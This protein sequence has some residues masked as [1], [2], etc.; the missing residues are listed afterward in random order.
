MKVLG[1]V[2]WMLWNGYRQ[3]PGVKAKVL[4]HHSAL[5]NM[6][7]M[8]HD[9]VTL[10]KA[11]TKGWAAAVQDALH[12]LDIGTGDLQDVNG[13]MI[14]NALKSIRLC[15]AWEHDVYLRWF[16]WDHLEIGD[17]RVG[18]F[19]P[20]NRRVMTSLRR[21]KTGCHDLNIVTGVEG[22]IGYAHVVKKAR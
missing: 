13:N 20:E 7:M 11:S 22:R 17:K 8:M 21:Y 16:D 4:L 18:L 12:T 1:V 6:M 9:R 5:L 10:G 3:V 14:I 15:C 19:H 2:T